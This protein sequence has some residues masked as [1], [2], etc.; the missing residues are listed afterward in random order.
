MSIYAI[1]DIHGSLNALQTIFRQELIKPEDTVVFLGDYVDRGPDTKGVIDWLISNKNNYHFEFL[2]GN[3]EIMMLMAKMD[4][5][6]VADWLF[7]GGAN[8][9]ESYGIGDDPNWVNKIDPTHWEFLNDCLPYLEI[10]H[11]IFVHGGLEPGKELSEQD[12]RHLYWKKYEIPEMYD[13]AKT[14]ICGHTSRKNGKIADFGHTICIDTYAHGGKWLTC[15][16]VETK[17]FLRANNQGQ[18]DTGKL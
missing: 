15:L 13:A 6:R 2:L 16:N 14:V 17:A 12:E 10:G 1:G 8:T 11:Y 18:I 9:L 3:H 5:G 4:P 7:F